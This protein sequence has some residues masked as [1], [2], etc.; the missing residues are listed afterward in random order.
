MQMQR[1]HPRKQLRGLE[2]RCRAL[3]CRGKKAL[4]LR[5]G[6]L[7]VCEAS[8]AGCGKAGLL[9]KEA[10][11]SGPGAWVSLRVRMRGVGVRIPVEER[12][13]Y[14]AR[15]GSGVAFLCVW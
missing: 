1:L 7:E 11:G 5:L 12:G 4:G 2:V 13:E 3:C 10:P 14:G 15:S 9:T 8:I 6:G